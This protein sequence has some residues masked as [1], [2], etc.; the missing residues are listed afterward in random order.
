MTPKTTPSPKVVVHESWPEG[1]FET[2][3]GAFKDDPLE[4]P[5]ELP[6]ELDEPRK[7]CIDDLVR[8]FD[9]LDE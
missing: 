3:F 1:F 9:G 2:Y 8:Y 4:E 7:K 5:E 6:W